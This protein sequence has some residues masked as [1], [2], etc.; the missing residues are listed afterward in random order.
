VFVYHKYDFD[1]KNKRLLQFTY[2]LVYKRIHLSI[3]IFVTVISMT[4][5]Y[6]ENYICSHSNNN[7]TVHK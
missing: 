6:Q 3:Y 1:D 4:N 5:F 2:G 7:N